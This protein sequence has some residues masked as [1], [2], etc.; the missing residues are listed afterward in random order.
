MAYSKEII[1]TILSLTSAEKARKLT[2]Q[3]IRKLFNVKIN[4]RTIARINERHQGKDFADV[5]PYCRELL[6]KKKMHWP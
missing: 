1:F 5:M 2:Q 3:I 6:T 4:I